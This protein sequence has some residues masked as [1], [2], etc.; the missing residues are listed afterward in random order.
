MSLLTQDIK[1]TR[2]GTEGDHEDVAQPI[3]ASVT[4]YAG[5]VALTDGTTGLLKRATSGVGS[6]G[7]RV[8]GL[9]AR[10]QLSPAAN[11]MV[12]I[13]TGSFFLNSGSGADAIVQGNVG[14]TCYLIDEN[15]VGLTSTGRAIAGTILAVDT[16]QPGG[17]A[18]KMGNA[19]STGS[20]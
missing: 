12:N 19:Q 9:I 17:V 1:I 11:T 6:A 10:Q 5:S 3:G 18:V 7:D 16:T 4:L 13:K 14:Q 20:P 8:W 2:Y 15:T